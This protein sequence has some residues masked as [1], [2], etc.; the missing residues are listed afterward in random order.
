MAARITIKQEHSAHW[1]NYA[2]FLRPVPQGLPE[3]RRWTVHAISEINRDIVQRVRAEMDYRLAVCRVTI[4]RHIEQLRVL[5]KKKKK[6]KTWIVSLSVCWSSFADFSA[7]QVYRF[8]KK[9][10]GIMNNPLFY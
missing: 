3:L 2:T 8:Y 10:S 9:C 6:E 1:H 5:K 7:I 4:G